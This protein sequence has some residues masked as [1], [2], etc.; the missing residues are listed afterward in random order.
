MPR[1][2]GESSDG[3][4]R[5]GPSRKE[6]ER[7]GWRIRRTRPDA[8]RREPGPIDLNRYEVQPAYSGIQTFNKLPLCL[9]QDDLRAGQVDVAIC[10]APVDMGIGQRGAAF[11]PSAI[12]SAERY[13]V[14]PPYVRTHQHV[15]LDPFEVLTVVDYGDAAVHPLSTE[16]SHEPIRALVREIAETGATPI[17][18]GGDHSIAWPDVAAIADVYGPGTVGV[19]HFDA[20]ADASEQMLGHLHSH[21]TPIRRLIDDEHLPG[22]NFVQVG[23]RGYYPDRS[24]LDWM[25]AQGMRSHFMA[26]VEADGMDTVIDR[27]I[28]EALDGP[29]HLYVS[30]DIDVLDPA[31]APGTGTP[32]PGGLTTRELFPLLRRLG[33]EVGLVGA[34]VVEVCPAHDPGYTTALNAHRAVMEM[35]T[36]MAMRKQGITGSHHLDARARGTREP[37]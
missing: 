2:D 21:G 25:A 35:I 1:A 6:L 16:E 9:T 31:Y 28:D 5:R 4:G 17:V 26:E 27:A 23:L 3:A 29:D 11:G 37:R 36:G 30:L 24:T 33:H 18:L 13:L 12:R 14:G 15:A 20:H 10:G 7:S 22:R 8:P 34:E 32:E 19:V